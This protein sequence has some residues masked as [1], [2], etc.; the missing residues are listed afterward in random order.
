VRHLPEAAPDGPGQPVAQLRAEAR[1]GALA[2]LAQAAEL[3]AVLG[4]L[5]GAGVEALAIKGPV[6]A[7]LAYGDLGL[8]A[9]A[10]LDLLVAPGDVAAA[11]A[12]L[13]ARGYVPGFALPAA[14]RARLVRCGSELLFR[15]PSGRLVDL[16]WRLL[17][18]GYSFSP[19]LD[20]LF[21]RRQT[22]RVGPGD[23]TSLAVEPT[24]LF[25]LLHGI[26]HVWKSLG[27][28]CDVAELVR[29][30]PGL[31]WDAVAGWSAGA[32]RRRLIDVGLALVHGLLDAPVPGPLLARGRA[33]RAVGRIA[34][35]L[36]GRLFVVSSARASLPRTVF[37][38]P[39]LAAMQSSAD[40]L[41]FLHDVALRP[42][43]LEWRAFPVPVELAPLHYFVR[44]LRLLWKRR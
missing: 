35:A 40:R 22:V 20:G 8:R 27:W 15:D 43:P 24:L 17:P 28:L 11:S 3:V 32:G 42:T 21:A 38:Y 9:F 19:G 5:R 10:D 14:W 31:D 23:V 4:G 34:A 18:R 7:A 44:P 26:K 16:H 37:K 6:S 39:Y 36:A 41:R 30:H 25:L 1:R 29:R 2:S 33:D 13:E 12:C